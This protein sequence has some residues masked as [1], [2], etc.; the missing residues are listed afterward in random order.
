LTSRAKADAVIAF[1]AKVKNWP[2]LE[3]AV[4]AKIED[5]EEFVGWWNE[6]V[7]AGYGGDRSK[8]TDRVTLTSRENAEAFTGITR[9]Q[10]SRWRKHLADKPKY[11][12]PWQPSVGQ[13]A[14]IAARRKNHGNRL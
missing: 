9:M 4:D 3:E 2:L 1:A 12:E 5:Q 7:G 11:R 6:N 8:V 10:V 13:K 14:L